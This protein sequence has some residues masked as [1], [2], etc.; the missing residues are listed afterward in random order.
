MPRRV[1]AVS[2]SFESGAHA[3]RCAQ[4]RRAQ[5][6][7]QLVPGGARGVRRAAQK[8]GTRRGVS[9]GERAGAHRRDSR[10][11]R[12]SCAA[13]RPS[14]AARSAKSTSLW[15]PGPWCHTAPTSDRPPTSGA[16][17]APAPPSRAD[18]LAMAKSAVER[19]ARSAQRR[20]RGVCERT[21]K[22]FASEQGRR[23]H[24]LRAPACVA[25]SRCDARLA[26][27]R[28]LPQRSERRWRSRARTNLRMNLRLWGC[29]VL[30]HLQQLLSPRTL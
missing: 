3:D 1:A 12:A 29:C 17:R 10:A 24:L 27:A 8:S 18:G 20:G 15:L 28:A 30:F 19:A 4:S 26:A 11:S 6:A 13:T 5:D 2:A 22:N 23:A 14:C 21:G 9:A 7:L 16:R 25:R